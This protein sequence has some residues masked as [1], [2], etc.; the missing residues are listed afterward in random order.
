VALVVVAV[1]FIMAFSQHFLSGVVSQRETI[2]SGRRA[3]YLAESA[4]NEALLDFTKGMN[5]PAGSVAG[6]YG[7]LR[8]SFSNGDVISYSF[9]PGFTEERCTNDDEGISIEEVKVEVWAL[10]PINDVAHERCGLLT[11]TA[12]IAI[13]LRTGGVFN[14]YIYR[15]V[16]R[17]YELKQIQC[18]PPEPFGQWA[19][20]ML[21]WDYLMR[22]YRDYLSDQDPFNQRREESQKALEELMDEIKVFLDAKII[23]A[24][25]AID[26]YN[27]A[28]SKIPGYRFPCPR[29]PLGLCTPSRHGW[30]ASDI[31]SAVESTLGEFNLTGQ[32]V[33]NVADTD[34]A[35][36]QP[37]ELQEL[38]WPPFRSDMALGNPVVVNGSVSTPDFPM[39][40]PPWP[41]LPAAPV[42]DVQ[43]IYVWQFPSLSYLINVFDQWK[44]QYDSQV[45]SVH[46]N[47]WT[48]ELKRHENKFQ[49]LG[50]VPG[51][52]NKL[53]KNYQYRRASW[54]F[55]SDGE[56]KQFLAASGGNALKGGYWINGSVSLGSYSGSGSI[57]CSG[58]VNVSGGAT[59][60]YLTVYS[61]KNITAGSTKG[62]LLAPEGSVSGGPINGLVVENFHPGNISVTHDS[63]YDS[64]G[65]D[66]SKMWVTVSPYPVA[67]NFLRKRN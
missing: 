48:T 49:L 65:P 6:W 42:I 35:V 30:S 46:Q 21:R 50:G 23:I 2:Y 8:S 56:F 25:E 34:T 54:R 52:Y 3:L 13:P 9:Y 17:S 12:V 38:S 5:D 11:I 55:K 15:N 44:K 16:Q 10:Q 63:S 37:V 58:D 39:R 28:L 18:T 29:H 57:A 66:G 1:I 64:A 59:G 40:F 45:V 61:G 43:W 41:S 33:Q 53:G 32:D 20:F 47:N 26:K 62:A 4:I 27:E 36:L 67:T 24:V 19:L 31:E 14:R 60:G 7:K 22:A 51:S